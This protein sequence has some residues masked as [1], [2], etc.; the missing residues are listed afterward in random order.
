VKK[1]KLKY[2]VY[3]AGATKPSAK[4]LKKLTLKILGSAA[5]DAVKVKALEVMA[6]ALASHTSVNNCSIGV[7]K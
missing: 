3:I 2:G 7:A 6:A 5:G 1:S 4:R